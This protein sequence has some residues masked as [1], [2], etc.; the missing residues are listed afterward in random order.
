MVLQFLP[1]TTSEGTT[2]RAACEQRVV[3]MPGGDM[4][5]SGESVTA[6]GGSRCKM[7]AS[8]VSFR[9]SQKAGFLFLE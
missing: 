2:K 5:P 9:K 3:Q 7:G 1:G 8:L 6:R 4:R